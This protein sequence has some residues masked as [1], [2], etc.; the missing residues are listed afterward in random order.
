MTGRMPHLESSALIDPNLDLVVLMRGGA[1]LYGTATPPSDLD[2]KD[3]YLP[4]AR[5]ILLQRVQATVSLGPPKA[6]GRSA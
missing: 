2:L 1:H 6:E 3:V 4:T 5:E